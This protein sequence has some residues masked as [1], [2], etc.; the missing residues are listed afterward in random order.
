MS[1]VASDATFDLIPCP[2][3]T[4]EI[5]VDA[6]ACPQCGR[7]NTWRHPRL[8][9]VIAHLEKLDRVTQNEGVG[10]TLRLWTTVKNTRQRVGSSLFIVSL[11]LLI[12][13]LFMPLLLGLALLCLLMG[14][15]LT[16][17]GLSFQTFH[18]LSID[19]RTPNKFVGV[20]DAAFW[21]DVVQIIRRGDGPESGGGKK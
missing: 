4:R 17:G 5:S 7:D 9:Q 1:G 8:V 3:C 15:V 2:S 6:L 10:H 11:A 19:L 13:G 18:E 16:F 12:P 21:A 14:A 20:Y